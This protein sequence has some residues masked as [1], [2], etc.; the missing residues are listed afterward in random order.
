MT[1]LPHIKD[2]PEKLKK[3]IVARHEQRRNASDLER[4]LALLV[5]RQI[6]KEVRDERRATR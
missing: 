3:Q 5:A 2:D 4:R 6:R 1:P